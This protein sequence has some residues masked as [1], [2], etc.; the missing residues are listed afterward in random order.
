M[1]DTYNIQESSS[2]CFVRTD[3]QENYSARNIR[4]LL[5]PRIRL[6][7]KEW[8]SHWRGLFLVHFYF[9]K[10]VCTQL[11]LT[12][13]LLTLSMSSFLFCMCVIGWKTLG[14]SYPLITCLVHLSY[15]QSVNE[16]CVRCQFSKEFCL[17]LRVF[18]LFY[19]K[20]NVLFFW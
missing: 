8:K 14:D 11:I 15:N 17:N 20:K 3:F 18:C 12:E 1:N 5:I 6:L 9:Y 19:C 2:K 13:C 7:V 16:D 10:V 4:N